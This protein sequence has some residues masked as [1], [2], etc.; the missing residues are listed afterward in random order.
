MSD[1]YEYKDKGLANL[2]KA[3]GNIPYAKLGILGASGARKEG[4]GPTNAEIGI[5]HEFG[6]GHLPLRSFLRMPIT[7]KFQQYLE[8]SGAFT[9]ETISEVIKEK[10]LYNWIKKFGILGERIVMDAF[11][12]GGFGQWKPSNMKYKKVHQTLVETQ[13]LRDSISSEVVV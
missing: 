2:I 6:E 5:R 9:K 13:Q 1:A 4:D 8:A 3:F 10:S 12:S 7:E 11:A